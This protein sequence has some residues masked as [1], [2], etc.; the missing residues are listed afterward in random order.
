MSVL[1]LE[2]HS[3]HVTSRREFKTCRRKYSYSHIERLS[4]IDDIKSTGALWLGTGIHHAVGM[5]YYGRLV[6]Q[7]AQS[8]Q[9]MAVKLPEGVSLMELMDFQ[10]L[11]YGWMDYKEKSAVKPDLETDELGQAMLW[12]YQRFS[13]EMDKHWTIVAVEVS[14]KALIPGTNVI[15]EGTID[16]IIKD[17]H[18]YLWIVDHKTAA[19]MPSRK[20]LDHDDQMTAYIWL[21]HQHGINVRGVIY[22]A[23]RKKIPTAPAILVGGGVSKNKSVDTTHYKYLE[24]LE[25]QGLAKISSNGN[26]TYPAE[27]IDIV[28]T[29]RARTFESFF[30]RYNLTRSKGEIQSFGEQLV[31]EVAD[32]FG[33]NTKYYTNPGLTC[34]Y[35]EFAFLCKVQNEKGDVKGVKDT[36]F[37]VKEHHER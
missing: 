28:E 15:L 7:F 17:A 13:A 27:Y 5:Y 4:P 2:P 33:P 6:D 37:R 19:V 22:N 26:F 9:T 29:T 1:T 25:E 18:G 35:C 32:M 10:D 24:T 34:N 23:I 11:R 30:V 31:D 20:Q 36:M 21:C 16:L 8:G 3:I 12:G 14:L